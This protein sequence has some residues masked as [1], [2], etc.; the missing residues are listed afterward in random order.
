MRILL[1]AGF[2]GLCG[3]GADGNVI[4]M[5][6]NVVA[7]PL[8]GRTV[9]DLA[10]SAMGGQ[11]CSLVRVEK[12]QSYCRHEEPPPAP[13]VFCARSLANVDCYESAARQ[14]LPVRVGAADGPVAQT[15]E[16]EAYRTRGWPGYARRPVA[17]KPA[18]LTV[19][20]PREIGG[21]S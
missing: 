5:A 13:P 8:F 19:T 20:P 21:G 1:L 4:G 14:P 18:T 3:C 9:P 7:V 6:A 2:L 15:P 17:P 10:I 11:D 16:Q 12:G